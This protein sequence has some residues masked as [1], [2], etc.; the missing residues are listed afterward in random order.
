MVHSVHARVMKGANC[1][2]DVTCD[3]C[4]LLTNSNCPEVPQKW[5]F[6]YHL[7]RMDQALATLWRGYMKRHAAFPS[8][9]ALEATQGQMDGFF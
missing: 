5:N 2:G 7:L 6:F 4:E 9:S 8:R 1:F 3:V